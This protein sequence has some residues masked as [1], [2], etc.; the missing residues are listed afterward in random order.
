CNIGASQ[1]GSVD[2]YQSFAI[3][4]GYI[5]STITVQRQSGQLGV[6]SCVGEGQ[7]GGV[8][9]SAIFDIG[10]GNVC[11]FCITSQ[12]SREGISRF[13]CIATRNS[14]IDGIGLRLDGHGVSSGDVQRTR[15]SS[16]RA[17]NIASSCSV[18]VACG[19]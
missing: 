15:I 7:R 8:L 2:R 12:S 9:H 13:V 16:G 4:V 19:F 18:Q 17:C 1:R 6:V 14:Q 11:G 5:G 10:Q 3:N